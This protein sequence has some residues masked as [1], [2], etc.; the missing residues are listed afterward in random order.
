VKFVADESCAKSVIQA[1]R[2][3]H[4]V[5]AIAEMTKG[6]ADKRVLERAVD[7]GRMVI[8]EDNDFGELVYA[9]GRPSAGFIFV[10]FHSRARHAK[11]A[12]VVEAV[13]QFGE[14]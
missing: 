7:A 4:D 1:L 9:R 6:T 13:T 8:T 3:G 11:S 5:L 2:S 12:T 10:K 14:R